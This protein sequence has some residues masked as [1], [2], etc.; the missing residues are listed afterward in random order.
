M[1]R[2]LFG[3]MLV[4][5]ADVVGWLLRFDEQNKETFAVFISF[6]NPG[7]DFVL[8]ALM[9]VELPACQTLMHGSSIFSCSLKNDAQNILCVPSY[10]ANG[11]VET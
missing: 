1:G 11:K 8:P 2:S 3:W 5:A 6:S 10:A 9:P 7:R 4:N